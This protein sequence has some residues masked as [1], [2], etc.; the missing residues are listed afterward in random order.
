MGLLCMSSAPGCCLTVNPA[1]ALFL[2]F[3]SF[4]SLCLPLFSLSFLSL[5]SVSFSLFPLSLFLFSI[6]LF[7]LC[8]SVC[9]SLFFFSISFSHSLS[10]SLSLSFSNKKICAGEHSVRIGGN[11]VPE[12]EATVQ[13][14]PLSAAPRPTTAANHDQEASRFLSTPADTTKPHT[15]HEA[16]HTGKMAPA[17]MAALLGATSSSGASESGT[18][19]SSSARPEPASAVPV[20]TPEL[21]R[22]ASAFG[23]QRHGR[24]LLDL[25]LDDDEHDMIRDHTPAKRPA[26]PEHFSLTVETMPESPRAAASVFD[27]EAS[28][29]LSPDELDAH[30]MRYSSKRQVGER[31]S[32]LSATTVDMQRVHETVCQRYR[33]DCG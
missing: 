14:Q 28:L 12:F 18:V 7:L 29:P 4:F 17:A 24:N 21:G 16:S 33:S 32:A 6:A 5:L 30:V 8:L 19:A 31:T 22:G 3:L 15:P 25:S 23:P 2:S 1:L 27:A 11:E 26:R 10:P 20:P 13:L 9:L